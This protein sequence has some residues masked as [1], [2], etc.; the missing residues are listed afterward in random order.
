MARARV[1]FLEPQ[2][3]EK[4]PD[5]YADL[6]L[7]V[8]TLHEMRA[9]QIAHYLRLVDRLCRGVFY[10]KQWRK[11]YN[12]LDEVTASK[13]TYPIPARWRALFDRSAI[14]PRSFFEALYLCRSG[15]RVLNR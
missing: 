9:D 13:E 7:T 5:D 14:A 4:L 12:D 3:L 8:S 10:T 1:V 15:A 2:Q 6:I 11:F